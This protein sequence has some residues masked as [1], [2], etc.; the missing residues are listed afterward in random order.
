MRRAARSVAD[1]CRFSLDEL[2]YEY[3]EEIYPEGRTPQQHLETC[4]WEGAVRRY[5]DGVPDSV[6]ATLERELAL[7]AKLEPVYDATLAAGD[8]DGVMQVVELQARI[9]GFIQGGQALKARL[10]LAA[11]TKDTAGSETMMSLEAALEDG[12][13]NL[14]VDVVGDTP[15]LDPSQVPFLLSMLHGRNS[16]DSGVNRLGRAN[17]TPNQGVNDDQS[18][19]VQECHQ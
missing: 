19:G 18:D 9:A 15:P 6:K 14:V 4:T 12:G 10:R 8:Y 1:A 5:P 17:A 16:A 3:P 13:P 7:I 2:R 11:R